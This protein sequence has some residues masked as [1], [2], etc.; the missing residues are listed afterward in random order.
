[1]IPSDCNDI[2]WSQS[3]KALS[4]RP[5]GNLYLGCW[6]CRSRRCRSLHLGWRLACFRI[7][8]RRRAAGPLPVVVAVAVGELAAVFDGQARGRL[9]GGAVCGRRNL[10][11]RAHVDQRDIEGFQRSAHHRHRIVFH[12]STCCPAQALTTA[13]NQPWFAVHAGSE[14]AC[15]VSVALTIKQNHHLALG[16]LGGTRCRSICHRNRFDRCRRCGCARCCC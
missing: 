16:C 11:Y 3:M 4:R 5:C 6:L 12:N 2:Q 15:H 9:G 7:R 13:C 8:V 10:R 1:M 14:F